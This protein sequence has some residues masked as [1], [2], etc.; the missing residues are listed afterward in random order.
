MTGRE[1]LED[2]CAHAVILY[3][4]EAYVPTPPIK[5]TP[6][7]RSRFFGTC[8]PCAGRG[9]CRVRDRLS[10]RGVVYSRDPRGRTVRALSDPDPSAPLAVSGRGLPP[11]PPIL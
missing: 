5:R 2:W 1:R 6:S 3:E 9:I 4:P 8:A 10:G 7:R 11:L